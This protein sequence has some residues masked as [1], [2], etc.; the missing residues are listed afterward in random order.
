MHYNEGTSY[1]DNAR[2]MALKQKHAV[3]ASR[4]EEAQKRPS[5]SDFY[6]QQ[7]K[8]QKLM[9]KEKI[10]GMR[11]LASNESEKITA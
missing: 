7:L 11:S 10:E 8:R 5:T 1:N 6:L 2:I 3:L 4:I 9:L